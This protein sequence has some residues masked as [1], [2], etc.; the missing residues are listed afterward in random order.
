MTE[1]VG[2]QDRERDNE[3]I[4]YRCDDCQKEF[5][6]KYWSEHAPTVPYRPEDREKWNTFYKDEAKAVEEKVPK[7]VCFAHKDLDGG[8]DLYLCL[9]HLSEKLQ[10]LQRRKQ[11][12]EV[13]LLKIR[14]CGQVESMT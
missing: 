13:G 5:E 8:D 12:Y 4:F 14:D 2:K 11:L 7:Q 6:N 1:T 3:Y 9:N 10:G